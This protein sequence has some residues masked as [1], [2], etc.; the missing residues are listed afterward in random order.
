[1]HGGYS[2][3]FSTTKPCT[4]SNSR[5]LFVTRIISS[6]LACA[7]ISISNG[8]IG[9]PLFCR[10]DRISPYPV[11]QCCVVLLTEKIRAEAL[12]P[13]QLELPV[14]I[15]TVS[16]IE[17]DQSLIGDAFCVGQRLEVVD[18]AAVDVDGDL[19]FQP[20]RV[21][22][23]SWIQFADVI[24]ISHTITSN[25]IK[26]NALLGFGCL[27]CRDNTDAVF[28]V[29]VAMAHN[30]NFLRF[31]RSDNEEAIFFNGMIRIVK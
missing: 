27:P 21:W 14:V 1:M 7:A 16:Q 9:V 23:F 30:A 13:G 20:V 10:Q 24:F 22:I 4:R 5:T 31:D 19:L 3:Q 28:V 11:V 25:S 29:T 8:P 15:G 18:G 12:L 2:T 17:V 26:I 6:D